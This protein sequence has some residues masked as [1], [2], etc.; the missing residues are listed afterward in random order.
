MAKKVTLY[1]EDTEIK[2]LVSNGKQIEKW[3]SLLLEPTLVRDGVIIDQEKV[4][5]GIKTMFKLE[6]VSL[7][8]VDVGLSGLNSIFRIVSLPELAPSM[9]TE[10]VMNEAGRVMPVP[11]DQ[12]YLSYQQIPSLKGETRVFLMAYPRNSADT[13]VKT[14]VSAGLKPQ[15][16]ELAP[17]ALSRCA[18]APKA[19]IINSWLTYLDIVVMLESMP[20][21]I[22]SLSLPVDTAD[23]NEKLP[24]ITEELNRT[25]A[26]YNSSYPEA[27]L[28]SS[29]PIFVCGDLAEEADSWEMLAGTNGYKVSALQ[30]PVE[31]PEGF[32]PCKFMV[33]VGMA[34]KGQL[35]RGDD[36]YY[37]IVDIDAMP[38]IYKPPGLSLVRIMVPVM[39]VIA[40]GAVAWGTYFVISEYQDTGDLRADL[41]MQELQVDQQQVQVEALQADKADLQVELAG[42]VADNDALRLEIA[43]WNEKITQQQEANQQPIDAEV[44]ATN[45]DSM[46][47]DLTLGLDTI[48][49]YLVEI[50][51]LLPD[52]VTLLN[53]DY[54]DGNASLYGLA[55]TE[56]DVFAYA[57][58]LRSSSYFN[59]VIVSSVTENDGVYEFYFFLD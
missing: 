43:D 57:K 13:L 4:A 22:R 48:D 28:D 19:V 25:I 40:L 53:V 20:Q 31:S 10:A 30:P 49:D 27:P 42:V 9:L 15:S 35:P 34:L 58:A 8:K 2:L 47:A 26:F 24:T 14:I 7:K 32:S 41:S 36:S 16:M 6:G 50:V 54:G 29:V 55:P 46:L 52:A 39:V 11:L 1:I 59:T 3:A 37:S 5:E 51:N 33:N 45:L 44:I 21:V 17:L 23:I 38:G 18:N 56:G 12:V